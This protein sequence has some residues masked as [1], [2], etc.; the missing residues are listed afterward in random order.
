MLKKIRGKIKL[1]PK[2]LDKKF[3]IEIP[4][5]WKPIT[6]L[7]EDRIRIRNLSQ[8]TQQEKK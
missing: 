2:L 7:H 4:R 8:E 3:P 1:S 5:P 6:I